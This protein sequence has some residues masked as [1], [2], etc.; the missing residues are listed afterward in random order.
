MP[1][2]EGC[3][4]NLQIAYN[5]QKMGYCVATSPSKPEC[6]PFGRHHYSVWIVDDEGRE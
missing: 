3:K 5:W 2:C 1:N 6:Y 4:E